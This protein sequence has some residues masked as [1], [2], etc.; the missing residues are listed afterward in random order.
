MR[1]LIPYNDIVMGFGASAQALVIR[2][3]FFLGQDSG[4]L[5]FPRMTQLGGEG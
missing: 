5:V 3:D 4:S 2:V 1:L